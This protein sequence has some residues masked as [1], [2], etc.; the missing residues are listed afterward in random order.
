MT[1]FNYSELHVQKFL[2]N[3]GT[4]ENLQSEFSIKSKRHKE[5]NNLVLFKYDQIDSP[6][7]NPI[8][9]EC[10]GIILDESN[11]W[12]VVSHA[13][14]KFFNQGEGHAATIDWSTARVQEKMDGSLCVLY[15]YADKWHVATSGTPDAS[16]ELHMAGR[17]FAS[18]FWEIY[19]IDSQVETPTYRNACYY[20]ELTSPANR[21]VVQYKE[22]K[23][24]L[25]GARVKGTGVE[26]SLTAAVNL[27][28][29][30][31]IPVV[32]EFPI[33]NFEEIIKSFEDISPLSQEGYVVV[34]GNFARVKVKH[35]GYIALHHAKDGMSL[36]AFVEI[37]RTGEVSEVVV[38]FPEF[39]PNIE[40]ARLR[41]D[42][43]VAE[44]EAD[45]QRLKDIASQK[46]FAIQAVKTRC[47]AALF[48][49]RAKK[50]LS[51]REYFAAMNI[52]SLMM[53]LGYKESTQ[54]YALAVV[55]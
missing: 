48:A 1:N 47:S 34:D 35:P 4:P 30:F 18:M 49:L 25:L 8:V 51:I 53:L 32:R 9:Q 5:Y 54:E 46:D 42:N 13:F 15:Y 11:N 19:G 16:G 37:A 3:G 7:G 12:N 24:T 23:L 55:T 31:D 39:K 17:T 33:S 6:M 36:K 29:R 20:F 22:P 38:A 41:L 21:V 52:N 10:R 44:V 40:E 43:L 27:L 2:R 14:N 26:V 45:Y 28:Q 50:A